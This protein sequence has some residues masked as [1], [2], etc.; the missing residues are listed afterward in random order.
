MSVDD[1]RRGSVSDDSHPIISQ[2]LETLDLVDT[3]DLLPILKERL[4]E[5][6]I[7]DLERQMIL[8]DG[9]PRILAQ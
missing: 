1:I 8:I 6:L 9:F 5:A 2:K 3:K 4:S 7:K